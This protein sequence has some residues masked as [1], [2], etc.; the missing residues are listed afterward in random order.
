MIKMN[1]LVFLQVMSLASAHGQMTPLRQRP[2][3]EGPDPKRKL[4]RKGGEKGVG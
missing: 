3:K 4:S 2:S 1:N